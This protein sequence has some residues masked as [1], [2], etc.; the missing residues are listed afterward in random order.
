[1]HPPRPLS[2]RR[3]EL[4]P[5]AEKRKRTHTGPLGERTSPFASYWLCNL[6]GLVMRKAVERRL[7]L[8][9]AAARVLTKLED[10]PSERDQQ[11]HW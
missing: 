11:H 5:S 7:V 3:L 10:C 4:P 8:D 2:Q 6:Q 9:G 1:M